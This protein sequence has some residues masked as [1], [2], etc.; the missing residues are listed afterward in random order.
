MKTL[1]YDN[2]VLRPNARDDGLTFMENIVPTQR[3]GIT[4]GP[5]GTSCNAPDYA[6]PV[7]G[8]TVAVKNG[9]KYVPT[10]T[11]Q[12][13]S[14]PWQ[15]NSIGWVQ[16]KERNYVLAVLTT[17]DPVGKGTYGFDYGIDTIQNV[18]KRIWNNLAPHPGR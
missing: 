17:D 3:W 15:V 11:K 4:C 12:D 8:V 13:D 5:W 18:S 1:A 16:G 7:S 10:C 6:D 2:A 9:W 14:C